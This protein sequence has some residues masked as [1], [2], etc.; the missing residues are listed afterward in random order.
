M[1][2]P[3]FALDLMFGRELAE[4]VSGGA[5]VVPRRAQDLGFRFR[6]PELEEALRDLL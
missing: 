3:G 5:R 1:P 4:T 6:H 2:V